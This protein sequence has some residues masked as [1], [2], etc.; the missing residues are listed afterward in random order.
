MRLGLLAALI[1]LLSGLATG[2]AAKAQSVSCPSAAVGETL[3]IVTAN[4]VTTCTNIGRTFATEGI[5]ILNVL[6]A[7][8]TPDC[9][10]GFH[11]FG[12]SLRRIVNGSN[13][14]PTGAACVGACHVGPAY[15]NGPVD[16][17]LLS[18]V[19]TG[20]EVND[21]LFGNGSTTLLRCGIGIGA[22]GDNC[23]ISFAFADGTTGSFTIVPSSLTI[24]SFALGGAVVLPPTVTTLSPLLAV[25]DGTQEVSILGYN[26]AAVTSVRLAGVPQSFRMVSA[27]EIRFTVLWPLVYSTSTLDVII[28]SP[29][30]TIMKSIHVRP[31]YVSI[32]TTGLPAGMVGSSYS[33]TISVSGGSKMA[34]PN[35]F[36][37]LYGATGLPGG[38][39]IN[40]AGVIS[41]QPT[42]SG[43]FTVAVTVTD[44]EVYSQAPGDRFANVF[45][46]SSTTSKTFTLTVASPV[47]VTTTSLPPGTGGQSYTAPLAAS[48]GTAPYTFTATGL[49]AGLAVSG[50][51]ITGT[52]TQTGNFTVSI[53]A[54]DSTTPTAITSASTTL[55]LSIVPFGATAQTITFAQPAGVVFKAGATVALAA[56]ASSGLA[57][58]FA[59]TPPSVCTV[60][61]A[62]ATI[63]AAGTCTIKASQAGNASFAAAPDV[64]QSF[65]IASAPSLSASA[66]VTPQKFSRPGET[67]T[68]VITLVNGGGTA[69][70]GIKLSEPRLA[71]ITCAA[72]TLAAG[73]KLNCQGTTQTTSADLAAGKISVSP[74]LTYTYAEAVP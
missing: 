59:S 33:T 58:T 20:G 13:E 3:N 67:L 15:D 22:T 17:D 32:T 65:A 11:R 21:W 43:A 26:L 39:S 38:L 63:V 69:A 14:Q 42:Q 68:F 29:T 55:S 74:Q 44:P 41:G 2:G 52:P 45:W 53:T 7:Q 71:N 37:Y 36:F 35:R 28:E 64:T 34:D 8:C 16:T 73:G 27:S 50:A 40:D 19:T 9:F 31:P 47:S 30:G 25:G 51:S 4:G 18:N 72:T 61:G 60:S 66:T 57:V 46:A 12:I 10:S 6:D 24:P 49:P 48:G 5:E 70:T 62:T 54:T 56:T 23:R 1:W